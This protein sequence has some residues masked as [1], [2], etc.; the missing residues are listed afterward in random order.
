MKLKSILLQRK[1]LWIFSGVLTVL[2]KVSLP[3][4]FIETWYSKGLFLLIREFFDFTT[5]SLPFALLYPLFF[6]LLAWGGLIFCKFFRSRDCARSKL[7]GAGHFLLALA[8]G[9]LVLFQFLWGFNYGR[10]PL[11][12]V[13]KLDVQLM[14]LKHLKTELEF[15]TKEVIRLREKI[16]G[17]SAVPVSDTLLPEDLGNVMRQ[18]LAHN[19][20][21]YGYPATENIRTRM[22]FPKGIL[23]RIGTAGFYLPFTGEGHVDAGLH[24]LQLPFVVAHELSH[25]S[26]FGDEGT[27]NFLAYLSC[28]NSQNPF[29]NYA[30]ELIYWRYVASEFQFILPEEFEDFKKELPKGVLNDLMAIRQANEQYPDILPGLRDAIYNAYLYLQGIPEGMENYN[31]VIR[32]V[33]AWRKHLS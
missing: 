28:R 33:Y 5:A 19:L 29:L 21:R 10:L 30:G 3:E 14:S 16:S 23:L 6:I 9:V 7:L 31:K 8:C 15:S 18:E 1:N 12:K 13:M 25:A 11:E 27:C 22:L 26:G 4:D 24:H 17:L 32:L 2:L 20:K